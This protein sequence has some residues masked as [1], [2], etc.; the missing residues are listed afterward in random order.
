VSQCVCVCVCLHACMCTVDSTS[1]HNQTPPSHPPHTPPTH[2]HTYQTAQGSVGSRLAQI[3]AAPGVC[4]RAHG[5]FGRE[6]AVG[7]HQKW[8]CTWGVVAGVCVCASEVWRRHTHTPTCTHTSKL[9]NTCP[10]TCVPPHFHLISAATI[11]GSP[12]TPTGCSQHAQRARKVYILC[13]WGGER[14]YVLPACMHVAVGEFCCSFLD[15]AAVFSFIPNTEHYKPLPYTPLYYFM[16]AARIGLA[17]IDTIDHAMLCC[18]HLK[19]A[20][21]QT[22]HTDTKQLCLTV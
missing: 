20:A 1:T 14:V 8:M 22:Q 17:S 9:V 18:L 4:V 5:G 7:G 19:N 12:S 13:V 15:S 21:F 16:A 6:K 3:Q 2:T 11:I 10:H